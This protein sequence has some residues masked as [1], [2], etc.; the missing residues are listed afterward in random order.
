MDSALAEIEH[1]AGSL[2][3]GVMPTIDVFGANL[4]PVWDVRRVLATLRNLN[5]LKENQK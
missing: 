3:R 4:D 5:R 2:R 1:L